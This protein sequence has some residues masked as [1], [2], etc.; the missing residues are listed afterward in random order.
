MNTNQQM[1]VCIDDIEYDTIHTMAHW[2]NW[3]ALSKEPLTEDCISEFAD[4]LDWEMISLYQRHISD[5]F[6]REF[7]DFIDWEMICRT[8]C[9]SEAIIREFAD[10]VYWDLISHA[11]P[12]EELIR[13]FADRV[14]WKSISSCQIL[15]VPFIKEFSDKVNWKCISRHQIISDELCEAFHD[16][17]NWSE[18]AQDK[19]SLH[20]IFVKKYDE[21]IPKTT[22]VL[23]L[24][25]VA[26]NVKEAI[27]DTTILPD[28]VVE[29]IVEFVL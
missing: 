5:D 9:L 4:Y 3:T 21:Y 24:V 7:A 10:D 17:L 18:I 8:G 11:A 27:L 20:Y 14:N 1:F 6:I 13:D 19:D 16:K 26:N 12:S 22:S 25:A 23:K 15:S 29:L 2:I 28:T